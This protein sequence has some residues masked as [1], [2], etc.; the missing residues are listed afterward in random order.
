[1]ETLAETVG[2]GGGLGDFNRT[3]HVQGPQNDFNLEVIFGDNF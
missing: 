1:M 2:R 3:L